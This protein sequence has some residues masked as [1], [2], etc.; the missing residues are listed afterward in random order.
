LAIAGMFTRAARRIPKVLWLIP[1]LLWLSEAPITTGT[2]RF[3]A[4]L[5]PFFILLA[6]CALVSLA[7]RAAKLPISRWGSSERRLGSKDRQDP[8]RA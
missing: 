7:G 4:V 6:G 8:A 2:P 3:R 5:D 1:F